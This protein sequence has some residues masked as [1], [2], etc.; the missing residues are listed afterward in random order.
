MNLFDKYGLTEKLVSNE[1][2]SLI[3]KPLYIPRAGYMGVDTANQ[4]ANL[5][6]VGNNGYIRSGTAE[7][8][9]ASKGLDFQVDKNANANMGKG[10]GMAT[11]CVA[12]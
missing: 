10:S 11:R 7:K 3:E 8:N 1:E 12:K 9:T 2:Y 6:L 4:R 5:D